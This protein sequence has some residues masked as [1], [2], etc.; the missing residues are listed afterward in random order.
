MIPA[1]QRELLSNKIKMTTISRL[2]ICVTLQKVTAI[3]ILWKQD[4]YQNLNVL[5]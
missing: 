4:L 3:H 1:P 5:P 2:K